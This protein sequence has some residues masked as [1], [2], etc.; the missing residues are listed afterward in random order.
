MSKRKS[1]TDW[2]RVKAVR[3]VTEF[4]TRRKTVLTTRTTRRLL[5]P[6]FRQR[7]P[8]APDSEENKSRNQATRVPP[9]LSRRT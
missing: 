1:Q 5:R 7:S 9:S 2:K 4:R 8:G 6:I 3:A